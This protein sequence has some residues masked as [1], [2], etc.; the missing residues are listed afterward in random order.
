MLTIEQ[1][2]EQKE[3]QKVGFTQAKIQQKLGVTKNSVARCWKMT[4]AEFLEAQKQQRCTE[5][6]NYRNFILDILR[7]HPQ[8]RQT[9]LFYRLRQEF[10]DFKLSKTTLYRYVSRLREESGL[11]QFTGRVYGARERLPMGEEAQVD[12][13]Q[14]KMKTMYGNNVKVYFFCMVLSYSNFRFVHFE[15]KPFTT[16]T[17]IRAHDFA[18]QYFRGRPR[19]ILY[20]LD[21]VFVS[22]ENY[23]NIVFVKDFEDYVRDTGFTARF[24]HA[25]DPQSKGRVEA[26]VGF[27]KHTFLDGLVYMEWIP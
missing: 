15:P 8:T 2:K 13:G 22:S 12:F 6:E 7:V 16:K 24:C 5:M 17:A 19:T 4:E 20:D 26:L 27:V 9:S 23:G 3:L 14:Y 1:F 10:P 21:S 18:F 11:Y 25:R